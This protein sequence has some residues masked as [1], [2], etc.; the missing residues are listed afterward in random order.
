MVA[1]YLLKNGS[2]IAVALGAHQS[3]SPYH[4]SVT[5]QSGPIELSE[6]DYITTAVRIGNRDATLVTAVDDS[7]FA[8]RRVQ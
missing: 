3:A 2:N 8:G 6:G 4:A 7:Y 1:G 5:V